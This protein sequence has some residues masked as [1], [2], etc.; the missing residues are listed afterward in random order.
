MTVHELVRYLVKLE[1]KGFSDCVVL[2]KSDV[3]PCVDRQEIKE[4]NFGTLILGSDQPL[5]ITV[6]Y[7]YRRNRD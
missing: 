2:L 4:D 1:N 5:Y 7:N 6:E 3:L